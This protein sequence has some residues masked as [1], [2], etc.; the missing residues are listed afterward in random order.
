MGRH[1]LQEQVEAGQDSDQG[2]HRSAQKHHELPSQDLRVL[3]RHIKDGPGKGREGGGEVD[4]KQ[5]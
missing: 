5:E 2:E 3:I 4:H 1:S